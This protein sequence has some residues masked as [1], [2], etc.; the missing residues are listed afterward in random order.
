MLEELIYMILRGMIIGVV[1]SAPMGPVGIFCIQRTLDKGRQSGFF[2]GVG[3]AVSDLIYCILT[4]FCL[5]F[6]EGFINSHRSPIQIL[7]SSVLIGFGI[8]LIKK[9]PDDTVNADPAQGMPSVEGDILKGFA[10]TFSNPLILFL[11][12]GLFAQFNFV[13]EGMTFWHYVLGFIG[14]IGGALGWWWVVTYFVD[15]LRCHFNQRTMKLINT[16]VGVIILIFAAVGILSATSIYAHGEEHMPST[17]KSAS[18]RVADKSM[19]GWNADMVDA[20]GEGFR[21]QVMPTS[22]SEPFRDTRQ[23]ALG[24]GVLDIPSG[25]LLAS[26]VLKD[27]VDPYKG[28]NSW[29]LVKDGDTWSLYAGNR[30]YHKVLGFQC[31]AYGRLYPQIVSDGY[32]ESQIMGVDIDESVGRVTVVENP[33]DILQILASKKNELPG[34]YSLFDFD[35]DDSYARIGGQYRL[36]VL[37]T[38]NEGDYDLI[39]ISGART[40]PGCWSE[41]M[42][43][44]LLKSTPF[45][46]IFDVEWTDAEGS[47]MRHDVQADFDPLTQIITVRFPYQ[48]TIL[49]FRK[50]P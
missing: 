19:E 29:K 7:G 28:F 20:Y 8:W 37:P 13:I 18:F 41:G 14:I 46:N 40:L 36:A 49:R 16:S 33:R 45:G 3:A 26:S 43:K 6:I 27:G 2:T 48:N 39:Y 4:G 50:E 32:V 15:K 22:I 25:M 30:E 10:L 21:L 38:E 17:T 44:G 5:S 47:V 11:I 31:K 9:K 42:R 34:L 1:V 23:D 12:I 35:Q 24:V